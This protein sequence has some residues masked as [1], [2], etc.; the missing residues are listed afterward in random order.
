MPFDRGGA[1]KGGAAKG[2]AAGN[3][4]PGGAGSRGAAG[5]ADPGSPDPG[6]AGGA[7]RTSGART[8]GATSADNLFLLSR[9]AHRAKTHGGFAYTHE[10]NAILRWTTP[11]GRTYRDRPHDYRGDDRP[12]DG[13]S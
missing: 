1:G 9:H 3:G 10:G 11:L 8:V 6:D 13:R 7:R 5:S 4:D 12:P 2:S